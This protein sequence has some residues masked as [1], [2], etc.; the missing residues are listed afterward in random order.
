MS[1]F[2]SM[3]E[4]DPQGREFLRNAA[5]FYQHDFFVLHPNFDYC[6]KE[7]DVRWNEDKIRTYHIL[8]QSE[9]FG[10]MRAAYPALKA[11]VD[12]AV[13]ENKAENVA[14]AFDTL[15]TRLRE[16]VLEDVELYLAKTSK[17][18]D[19]KTF[20][21]AV[22]FY[23]SRDISNHLTKSYDQEAKF[24]RHLAQQQV[25]EVEDMFR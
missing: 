10:E 25:R 1:E 17:K 7:G 3:L 8:K 20:E 12:A 19:H 14:A 5:E 23:F 21:E 24:I 9:R 11:L 6:H 4:E 16:M 22:R 18:V 13:D 15:R 2:V